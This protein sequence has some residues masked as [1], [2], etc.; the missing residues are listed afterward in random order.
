MEEV[1]GGYD[2]QIS[3]TDTARHLKYALYRQNESDGSWTCVMDGISDKHFIYETTHE[4]IMPK[5][6]TGNRQRPVTL[7]IRLKM[8]GVDNIVCPK[9][10]SDT[11]SYM[12]NGVKS[13]GRL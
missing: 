5:F 2:F 12:P 10:N 8:S 7:R 4:S 9:K 3:G 11:E 1:A 6:N 13:S